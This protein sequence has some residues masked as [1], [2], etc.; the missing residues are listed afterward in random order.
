MQRMATNYFK[1]EAQN[2]ESETSTNDRNSNDRN[3]VLDIWY[4]NFRF[5]SY[6]DIRV[7]D[8]YYIC[9]LVSFIFLKTS[10]GPCWKASLFPAVSSPSAYCGFSLR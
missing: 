1:S 3:R 6:F 5:V 9:I 10:R 2:Q 8:F 7:S 4:L